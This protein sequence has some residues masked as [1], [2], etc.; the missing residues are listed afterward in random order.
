M[1]RILMVLWRKLC[2]QLDAQVQKS[3]AEHHEDL[4][5]YL[6]RN[7]YFPQHG[8]AHRISPVFGR[9][10]SSTRIPFTKANKNLLGCKGRQVLKAVDAGEWVNAWQLILLSD[11]QSFAAQEKII[12][13]V[14]ND[15]FLQRY[16][17]G[18]I[19]LTSQEH[20]FNL[21]RTLL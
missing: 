7:G 13:Y 12:P 15:L 4:I 17:I 5:K 2:C 19:V 6:R 16:N 8:Q 1:R 11:K 14:A 3:V 21:T 20:C 10:N 18:N 9:E